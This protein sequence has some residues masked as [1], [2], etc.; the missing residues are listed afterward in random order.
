MRRRLYNTHM[1]AI[2]H[3]NIVS[4]HVRY[5]VGRKQYIFPLCIILVPLYQFLNKIKITTVILYHLVL[6]GME[7]SWNW[8]PF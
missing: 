5:F 3:N 6:W 4:D 8:P 2:V 7:V 1:Y